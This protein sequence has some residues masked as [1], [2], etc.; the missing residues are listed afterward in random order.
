M[1]NAWKFIV[2]RKWL[3]I[4][5]LFVKSDEIKAKYIEYWTSFIGKTPPP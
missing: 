1:H 4:D 2:Q 3:F 5:K